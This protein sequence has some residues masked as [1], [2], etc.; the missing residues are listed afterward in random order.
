MKIR[1]NPY[2]ADHC[3][4]MW[5]K[6]GKVYDAKPSHNANGPAYRLTTDDGSNWTDNYTASYFEVVEE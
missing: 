1:L 3:M 6:E 2:T 5:F 4:K